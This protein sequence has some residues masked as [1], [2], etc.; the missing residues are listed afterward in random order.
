MLSIRALTAQDHALFSSM[1]SE[2]YNSDAVLH[3]ISAD[4]IENCFND[5]IKGSEH[6][7]IYII[8]V[9]SSPA[10]FSNIS[11]TYSTEAGGICI[12]I[13]DLYVRPEF[14]GQG[15]GRSFIEQ[16]CRDSFAD[17]RVKRVRLEVE[18]GNSGAIRLYERL[19]FR[20]LDYSQMIIE[21]D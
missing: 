10:G 17:L 14:R 5:C 13:E 6:L 15:I 16:I 7:R 19:G 12:Q 2:F 8:E 21:A 20:R 1:M 9:D 3:P 11:V 4:K 18:S